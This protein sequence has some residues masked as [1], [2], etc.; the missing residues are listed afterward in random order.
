[1]GAGGSVA[2]EHRLGF[3]MACAILVPRLGIEPVSPALAGGFLTPRPPEESC[4]NQKVLCDSDDIY[5]DLWVN[6]L[7]NT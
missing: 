2:E 5:V 3:S 1:M 4:L 7:D 6:P